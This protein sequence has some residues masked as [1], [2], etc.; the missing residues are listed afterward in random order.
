MS[1][2]VGVIRWLIVDD[3]RVL[4]YQIPAVEAADP[5]LHHM[6]DPALCADH[7]IARIAADPPDVLLLDLQIPRTVDGT[8]TEDEG[9]KLAEEIV[10]LKKNVAIVLY[11]NGPI[12]VE[13]PLTRLRIDRLDELGVLGYLSKGIETATLAAKIALAAESHPVFWPPGQFLAWKACC[14]EA[15]PCFAEP[16]AMTAQ[17]HRLVILLSVFGLSQG[18]MAKQEGLSADQVE[19][20][21][22]AAG[23]K[24]NQTPTRALAAW[25]RRNCPDCVRLAKADPPE[26]GPERFR[27]SEGAAGQSGTV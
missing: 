26:P 8:P 1:P 24:M 25:A 13:D 19:R 15:H 21:L 9:I 10:A 23:E 7:A 14:R 5:R 18:E 2:E 20:S 11:R 6:D 27:A 12:E 3:T 4:K 17:E 16:D 22:R